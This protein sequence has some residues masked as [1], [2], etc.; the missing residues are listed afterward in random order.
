MSNS[1]FG[2]RTRTG[3][4]SNII[5]RRPATGTLLDDFPNAAV[6][7]SLRL[8][9]GAYTGSAIRV[10]R[11]NDNAEQDIGFT[12]NQ[13][14]TTSLA[15]FV[16][17]NS[18][19]VTT[20][21][22][23]SGNDR[24]AT[25]TTSASQPRIVA[26]GVIDTLNGKP[27]LVFDGTNDHLINSVTGYVIN[28]TS[29]YAISSRSTAVNANRSVISTGTLA[30]VRGFGIYYSNNILIQD[31]IYMQSRYTDAIV[32]TSGG[33]IP[34][35]NQMNLLF[36]VTTTV[37]D[38]ARYNQ[39][40]ATSVHSSSN[41]TSN[42]RLMIGARDSSGTAGLF[43]QGAISECGFWEAINQL[44]AITFIELNIN[45]YYNIF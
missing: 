45:T 29:I 33:Q 16:G 25:Q 23:Q 13:L 6:A 17:A 19:F 15:S 37:L 9:R 20:W 39:I 35:V 27:T 32:T 10:R 41:N 24:N 28:D 8:L 42:Q 31:G 34:S 26:S 36:G 22:D 4:I 11:S 44:P 21:Y 7:Y 3:E 40:Q 1:R 5:V 2:L 12:G 30:L 14:D 38:T 43:H 18:G